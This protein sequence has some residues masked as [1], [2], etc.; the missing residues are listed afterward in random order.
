MYTIHRALDVS[1]G[2]FLVTKVADA[3]VL[4]EEIVRLAPREVLA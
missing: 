3:A 1:T 4:R 2:E